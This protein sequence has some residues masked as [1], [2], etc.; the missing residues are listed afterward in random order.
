M[1]LQVKNA[2]TNLCVCVWLGGVSYL[3]GPGRGRKPEN[4]RAKM[5]CG[6]ISD[7]EMAKSGDMASLPTSTIPSRHYLSSVF[8]STCDTT[9]SWTSKCLLVICL[10]SITHPVSNCRLRPTR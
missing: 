7:H 9:Q 10:L 5:N 1:M 6:R 8:N 3:G 4:R 2:A